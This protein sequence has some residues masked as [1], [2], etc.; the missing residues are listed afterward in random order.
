MPFKDQG[1]T[2]KLVLAGAVAIALAGSGAALAWPADG[3]S[4]SPSSAAPLPAPSGRADSSP[5][6]QDKQHGQD[7]QD[8][9]HG[10]DKQQRQDKQ[11][12]QDKQHKPGKED[13][14][15][16]ARGGRLQ[17]SESVVKDADGTFRTVLA[18]RGTV[19]AVSSTSITVRSEDGYSQTYSVDAD[20]KLPAHGAASGQ[21]TPATGDD[22]AAGRRTGT[23]ADIDV[24]D[25]VRVFGVREGDQVTATR[26]VLG[27]GNLPGGRR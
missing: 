8:K 26:I 2:R 27:A 23:T 16:N 25:P 1:R 12:G 20:T 10:Q 17:R 14:D 19:T 5:G 21:R 6:H 22:E 7:K 3:P 4:P 13:K 18:Q 15:D 24:G 9:Q 11:H